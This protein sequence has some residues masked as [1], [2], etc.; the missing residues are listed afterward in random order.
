[1][2]DTVAPSVRSHIMRSVRRFNT[3]P[4]LLLRQAIH[5]AGLRFRIHR[6]DLAGKPDIVLPRYRL[7]IFVNGCFWHRHQGCKKCT[8]PKT[9]EAWW[10]K[11]FQANIER[12]KRT[13]ITLGKSGWHVFVAWQCEIEN[14]LGLVVS[15][16]LD[17]CPDRRSSK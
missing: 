1:M 14:E 8:T 11:K 5:R 12:D 3:A 15:K 17:R 7:A 4:E 13:Q 16:I 6:A 10:E 2:P 9:R